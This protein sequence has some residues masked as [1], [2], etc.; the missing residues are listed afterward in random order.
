MLNGERPFQ[1]PK[2]GD[3]ALQDF[4]ALAMLLTAESAPE[5]PTADEALLH[6]F[7]TAAAEPSAPRATVPPPVLAP[8]KL[9]AVSM[10][11]GETQ[12]AMRR[13]PAAEPYVLR[14]GLDTLVEDVLRGHL[15]APEAAL[16]QPW[17][18]VLGGA[19]AP[20]SELLARFFEAI[21]APESRLLEKASAAGGN[22]LFMPTEAAVKS[23]IGGRSFEALALGRVLGKCLLEGISTGVE[24]APIVYSALLG[25]D[26]A[27]LANPDLAL[28][29]LSAWDKADAARLRALTS[30]PAL[31]AARRDAGLRR[32]ALFSYEKIAARTLALYGRMMDAP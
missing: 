11:L 1:P 9:Q 19:R 22:H 8:T 27:V 21:T 30:D 24:F 32:A 15:E 17:Q 14:A 5:R 12:A 28:N 31:R 20:F 18:A 7:F 6:A 2:G 16:G 26:G 10:L 23:L 13:R 29:Q 4:V 3:K 25:Q